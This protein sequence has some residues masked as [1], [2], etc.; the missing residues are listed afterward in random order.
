MPGGNYQDLPD[1]KHTDPAVS[2]TEDLAAAFL[3]SSVYP[4]LPVQKSVPDSPLP[5]SKIQNQRT[6][7]VQE[8]VTPH[9]IPGI[10][11]LPAL[12]AYRLIA[13]HR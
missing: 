1:N 8:S 2:V 3:Q 6:H 5:A 11:G 7:Y 4:E 13:S 10:P 9:K 12:V